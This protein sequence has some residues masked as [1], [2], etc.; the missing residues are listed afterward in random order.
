MIAAPIVYCAADEALAIAFEALPSAEQVGS[1]WADSALDQLRSR[2]K[3][4]YI[5]A[6]K[7]RCCYCNRHLGSENHRLWDVE[8]VASR[9]KHAR[10][11]F[12]PTNLAA[13]CPDCNGRK[14]EHEALKNPKRKTYPKQSSD[15]RMLHPHF[16][17]FDDHIHQ[18]GMVYLPKT[19]KGKNTIYACDLMRFAQKF[20]DW[21]NSAADTS[22]EQEVDVVFGG[23]SLASQAAVD[24]II[25]KLPT[26]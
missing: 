12:K 9:S 16:D 7:T 26:K 21:E 6:Q 10:F 18:N 22:F 14:G 19:E 23:T 13:S 1:Y 4:F 17:T 20:I 5:A 24:E 2:V 25:A 3:T 8:H 15:F 11:M